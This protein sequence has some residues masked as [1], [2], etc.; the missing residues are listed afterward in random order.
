PPPAR[1][2]ADALADLFVR[3]LRTHTADSDPW[4]L[5]TLAPAVVDAELSM[6]LARRL[7]GDGDPD[8]PGRPRL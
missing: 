1:E 8:E 4:Q 2:H 6:A 7:R 5:R 3:D